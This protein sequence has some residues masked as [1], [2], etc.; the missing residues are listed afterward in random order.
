LRL[1]KSGYVLL[2]NKELYKRHRVYWN[3]TDITIKKGNKKDLNRLSRDYYSIRN[4]L[5]IIQKHQLFSAFV[6]TILR[7]FYKIIMGFKFGLQYGLKNTKV[8]FYAL[9]HFCIGKKGLASF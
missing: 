2:V 6:F 5:F 8:I 7:S 3:R 4:S 1:Q 9:F